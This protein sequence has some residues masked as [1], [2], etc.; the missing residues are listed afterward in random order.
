MRAK[1]HDYLDSEK[2]KKVKL[3]DKKEGSRRFS[4]KLGALMAA[5]LLGLVVLLR[6]Q[7]SYSV[8]YEEFLENYDVLGI[9]REASLAEA[10]KAHRELSLKWCVLIL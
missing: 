10:K 7:Q 1:L 3:K 8:Y 9:P 4:Y 6:Y 2:A 5:V